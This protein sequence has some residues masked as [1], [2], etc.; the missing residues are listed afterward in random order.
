MGLKN[1]KM[2]IIA[3]ISILSI[4]LIWGSTFIIIKKAI[5]EIPTFAFL[6]LRFGLASII[7]LI[8]VLFKKNKIDKELLKDGIILGLTLFSVFAFQTLSLKYTSAS[9]T[10]FLTGL[11]VIFAPILS[12]LFLKKIPNLYSAAG[13]VLASAGMAFI[14]LSDNLN[15]FS[16]GEVF[17]IINGFFIAVHILFTDKF[18]RNHDAL[19]LTLLQ[20]SVV[21]I[22]SMISY[23]LF[24]P[25][26][27]YEIFNSY[28]VFAIFMTAVLATVVAFFI[29]TMMQKYTT[30]TKAAIMFTM[31]PVSAAFFSYFIGNEILTMKQYSG[32]VMIIIA[33]IIAETGTYYKNKKQGME[34]Q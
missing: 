25:Q 22:L 12:A 26:V 15:N 21:A 19:N 9:I 24:E 8:I 2:E 4:A 23:I 33:M 7:L 14:T 5:E 18:S 17:G 6:A 20:I 10:G 3:D 13:V 30:P 16:Y 28:T 27:S 1:K 32:A 31:E 11:Y 34:Y 29:Q